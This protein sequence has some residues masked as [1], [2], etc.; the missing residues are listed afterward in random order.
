MSST[1]GPSRYSKRVTKFC[2]DPG[3]PGARRSALHHRRVATRPR[4]LKTARTLNNTHTTVLKETCEDTHEPGD[5]GLVV[6]LLDFMKAYDMLNCDFVLLA[7]RKFGFQTEFIHLVWRL[8]DRTTA[9]FTVNG[10]LQQPFLYGQASDKDARSRYYASLSPQRSSRSCC[11]PTLAYQASRWQ[12]R[13]GQSSGLCRRHSGVPRKASA[14][15]RLLEQLEVFEELSGLNVQP[16]KSVL[17]L[18]NSAVETDDRRDPSTKE[19]RNDEVPWSPSRPRRDRGR[20]LG[21]AHHRTQDT[22][23]QSRTDHV[24]G[25]REG[26]DPQRGRTTGHSLHGSIQQDHRLSTAAA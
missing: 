21:Q 7:M 6:V 11:K 16:K 19:R 3:E 23:G 12:K 2:Q 17:I 18:L 15:P 24:D 8:H 5:D 26:C 25:R 22:A 20:Q 10:D 9:S 4:A 1:T 14:L 13:D